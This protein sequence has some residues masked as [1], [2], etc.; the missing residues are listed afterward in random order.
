MQLT[1]NGALHEVD[2]EPDMPLLWVLRD[3]LNMTGTKFGCGMGLCGSC[4][5]H[6]NGAQ[7]RSCVL[8]VS[9]AVGSSIVTIEALNHPVQQAWLDEQVPQCGYCQPGQLMAA[10]AL[11]QTNPAPSAQEVEEWMT[12]LCRCAT[13]ARIRKGIQ[14]ASAAL[15]APAAPEPTPEVAPASPAPAA[16]GE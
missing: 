12:N 11:L 14:R 4:T 9:A 6:L 1:I 8:P 7:V 3:V 10:A 15:P 16:G 5:V 2:V 13:Y